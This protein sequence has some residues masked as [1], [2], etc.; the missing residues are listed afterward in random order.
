MAPKR[1]ARMCV[2][3]M[4]V[5][6]TFVDIRFQPMRRWAHEAVSARLRYAVET[7]GTT[8]CAPLCSQVVLS[9]RPIAICLLNFA[10]FWS[11]HGLVFHVMFCI[12]RW[13]AFWFLSNEKRNRLLRALFGNVGA[14]TLKDD[15]WQSYLDRTRRQP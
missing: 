15:A 4:C 14:S 13:I 3:C 6:S 10:L 12:F 5:D 11:S 1:H 7:A 2:S 9:A 8:W